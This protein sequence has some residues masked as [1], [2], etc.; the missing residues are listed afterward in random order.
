MRVVAGSA[1]GRPLK[2]VPG[3]GTRPTTDKV[4][5]AIFSMIGPFFDGGTALDL[6]A[7]TGGLAI[8][9]LSRGIDKAVFIDMDPKSIETVRANLKA[10]RL[11]GQAEVYRNEAERALKVLE[12]R[13]IS[14]DVVFLDP[15]YRMK[16]GDKLMQLMH[17][18]SMLNSGATIVLE[19]ESG[20]EYP[21]EFGQFSCIRHAVYGETAVSIY[22]YN[23]NEAALSEDEAA[24][25]AEHDIDE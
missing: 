23:E 9:A 2:A 18:K 5:E 7:G 8:E 14:L 4:K 22:K 13:G 15:P 3:M 24:G 1:K 21:G 25:E 19:H 10:T 6:F 16:N 11:E 20:Y 17:E 12:K